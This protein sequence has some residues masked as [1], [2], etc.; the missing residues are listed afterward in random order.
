MRSGTYLF[1]L[2]LAVSLTA[3]A[4][5][6]L[7][8]GRVYAYKK[9]YSGGG[10]GTISNAFREGRDPLGIVDTTR[11]L[12]TGVDWQAMMNTA[13]TTFGYPVKFAG[14]QMAGE[15]YID[16]KVHYFVYGP[17]ISLID[18]TS[19]KWYHIDTQYAALLQRY[20]LQPWK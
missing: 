5:R 4:H 6:Q 18:V 1:L 15:M 11:T 9:F 12:V 14:I 20:Y 8:V 3:F 7:N 2:V 10:R 16:G 13:K 17:P 19:R